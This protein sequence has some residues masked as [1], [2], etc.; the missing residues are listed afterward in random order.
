MKHFCRNVSFVFFSLS[1]MLCWA[2]RS[3]AEENSVDFLSDSFYEEGTAAIELN[4]PIEPFNRAMF[5]FNDSA[6][7]YV[8]HPVAKGYSAVVPADIRGVVWNFFSN[9]EE[10]VRF[11][12]CL[13]QARFSDAGTVLMRFLINTT[14]GVAGLGNPAGRELGFKRVEATLG[15]TLATWGVGDG[16]Y[17]VIPLY[18]P[19]TL[20]D[21]TGTLVDGLGMTPYYTFTN[22]WGVIAGIYT[23]KETNKLSLHLNDYEEM[24]KFSF[25]P[26]VAVKNGY[27]QYRKKLRDHAVSIEGGENL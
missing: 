18:G 6:Y 23:G 5:T 3:V 9:L 21:F 2:Q 26:Y 24:K 20:R 17:L 1:L 25:D 16:L 22:D 12:N 7:T 10:P 8:F 13:L 15:E 4:D 14:G 11:L 19:S 27:F